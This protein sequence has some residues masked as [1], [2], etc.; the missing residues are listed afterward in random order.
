MSATEINVGVDKDNIGAAARV[1][2]W[3]ATIS[4]LGR[5]LR[6]TVDPKSINPVDK[7]VRLLGDGLR[8]GGIFAVGTGILVGGYSL[9][10]LAIDRVNLEAERQRELSHQ[11]A[12]LRKA[13]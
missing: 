12:N 1:I 9:A 4:H 8:L 6:E 10:T 5:R 2:F 3:G 7:G 13:S 11:G